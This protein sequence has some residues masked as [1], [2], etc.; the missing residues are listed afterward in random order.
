MNKVVF[1]ND[2]NKSSTSDTLAALDEAIEYGKIVLCTFTNES[3]PHDQRIEVS[4]AGAAGAI[5]VIDIPQSLVPKQS[6]FPFVA[7][8]P[9]DSK[10]VK[11]YFAS[12]KQPTTD[13]KFQITILGAKTAPQECRG[14]VPL[15]PWILKPDIMVT[16][17]GVLAA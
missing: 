5:F 8:S 14:H 12:T 11:E 17:V 16:V 13:I 10:K 9:N 3:N 1:E 15:S 4:R 7:I 2:T 6:S